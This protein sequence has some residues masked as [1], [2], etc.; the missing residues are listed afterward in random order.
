MIKVS[1]C[2][3]LIKWVL[4]ET[5][6]LSQDLVQFL[7]G[8]TSTPQRKLLHTITVRLVLKTSYTLTFS[9]GNNFPLNTVQSLNVIKLDK[10]K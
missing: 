6:Q 7:I 2:E 9:R 5:K 8:K 1:T 3:N 10:G 4:H